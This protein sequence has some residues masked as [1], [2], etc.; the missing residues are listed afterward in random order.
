MKSAEMMRSFVKQI[1]EESRNKKCGIIQTRAIAEWK[2][3]LKN[4]P[5]SN[6]IVYPSAKR[7]SSSLSH[8]SPGWEIIERFLIYS[9]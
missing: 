3:N 4:D 8:T 9:I 2:L 1:A 5:E 7:R 6:I